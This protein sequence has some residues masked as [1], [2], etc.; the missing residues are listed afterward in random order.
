M[1]NFMRKFISALIFFSI[2]LT[3]FSQLQE[4][5]IAVKRAR[6]RGSRDPRDRGG[7]ERG[8]P[9]PTVAVDSRP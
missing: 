9:P 1:F 8:P 7:G 3:G 2:A 5:E 6:K 4:I